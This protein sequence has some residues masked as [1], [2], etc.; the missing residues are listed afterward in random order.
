MIEADVGGELRVAVTKGALDTVEHALFTTRKHAPSSPPV[1]SSANCPVAW[2]K[3]KLTPPLNVNLAVLR[4]LV[5]GPK[6]PQETC[7][8]VASRALIGDRGRGS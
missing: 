3:V 1:T 7:R 5:A 6:D 8:A 4:A 2:A